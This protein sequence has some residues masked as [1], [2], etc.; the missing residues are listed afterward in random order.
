M[1]T[2]VASVVSHSSV[3]DWPAYIVAGVAVNVSITGFVGGGVQPQLPSRYA[4]AVIRNWAST[5]A[6]EEV[7][8]DISTHSVVCSGHP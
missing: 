5:I 4:R 3:L 1:L 2:E 8:L 7:E 6:D